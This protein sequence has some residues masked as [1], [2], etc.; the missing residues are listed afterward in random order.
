MS[1]KYNLA[2]EEIRNSEIVH[3]SCEEFLVVSI[4]NKVRIIG[5]QKSFE[6]YLPVRLLFRPFYK[7]R[8]TRRFFRLDK[9]NIFVASRSKMDLI[10]LYQSILYSYSEETGLNK[11]DA[12]KSGR[13][14]LHN[15][16]ALTPSGKLIF[17]EYFG[18][19]KNIPVH[20]YSLDLKS[21]KLKISYTFPEGSIRHVHNCYWD[22]YTEKVWILTGDSDIE[23]HIFIA[24]ENFVS[25]KPLG[26]GSQVWRAVS[27]FFTEEAVY[28]LMDSPLKTSTLVKYVRSNQEVMLLQEFPSPIYY[29][30]SFSDGGYLVGTTHE[31]GESV[32]GTTANIYYSDD[33]ENWTEMA[34]YEHDG[35]SLRFMKYG[36]VGFSAGDQ[37][38]SSFYLFS[39]ALIGMDGKSFRCVLTV[40]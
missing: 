3:F 37:S 30:L 19:N 6:F 10:I 36:I 34:K 17:G 38:K 31:P 4:G 28:W 14:V 35:L 32:Q 29:S 9:M 40:D 27:A 18:N 20:I 33:L 5:S 8:L 26:G 11:I 22:P 12:I 15:A 2:L 25:V 7:F 16:A 1:Q 24:D 21:K 39:E 13:N 23:S